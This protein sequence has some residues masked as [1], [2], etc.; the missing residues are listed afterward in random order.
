MGMRGRRMRVAAVILAAG[1]F[2]MTAGAAFAAASGERTIT[3]KLATLALRGTAPHQA[4]EQLAQEW[5]SISGG[6]VQ[7][8][9]YPDYHQGESA[10]VD[11]MG[12]RGLDAAVMTYVG[13]SKI[14]KGITCLA[15]L[16]VGFRSFEEVDYVQEK[17][18]PEVDARLL[19]KGYI[20][21]FLGDLGWVHFFSKQPILLPDDLRKQKLFAWAGDAEQ[22]DILKSAGFDP[23]ALETADILTGLSSGLIDAVPTTPSYANGAQFYTATKHMLQLNWGP[24]VG[25]A[26]IRRDTWERIPAELRPALLRSA[27]SVGG[28]I[29]MASREENAS[30]VR[31]LQQKH[32]LQ[33]HRVTPDAEQAWRTAA[34]AVYPKIRGRVIPADLYDTLLRLLREYRS[35][36]P[37]DGK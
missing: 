7:L 3:I 6:R 28:R 35:R 14:D 25:G 17:L 2:I 23:V 22:I 37:R 10:M 20:P 5:K 4:L 12:V 36:A 13:L 11:K 18:R 33:V 32:G 1:L 29:K 34:E 16:P 9:V 21:L 27:A 31:A 19:K 8:I 15:S 30:A 24:L 26:V